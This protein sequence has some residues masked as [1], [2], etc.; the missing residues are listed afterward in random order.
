[1]LFSSELQ[2]PSEMFCDLIKD[3]F[4][5]H[6]L[7]LLGSYNCGVGE[8]VVHALSD[9]HH[10]ELAAMAESCIKG[11]N[12]K[13]AIIQQALR[14]LSQDTTAAIVSM[15]SEPRHRTLHYR[16]LTSVSFALVISYLCRTL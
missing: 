7:D 1:M 8:L 16:G 6:R 11:C 14:T 4:S 15:M 13:K 9:N 5:S 2:P 10:R 3:L 12:L